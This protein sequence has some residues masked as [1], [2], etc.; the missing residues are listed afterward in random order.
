[1]KHSLTENVILEKEILMENKM[2]NS[3]FMLKIEGSFQNSLKCYLVTELIEGGDLFRLLNSKKRLKE[4]MVKFYLAELLVALE[5]LH[6]RNI[7]YRDLKPENI[8]LQQNGHIKLADFGLCKKMRHKS[9]KTYTMCGTCEYQAPE[10]ILNQGYNQT[11][12]YWALGILAYELLYG[13]PPFTDSRNNHTNI[14]YQIVKQNIEFDDIGLDDTTIDFIKHLTKKN[15]MFRLGYNGI[16]EIKEHPFF[17]DIDWGKIRDLD[18]QPPFSVGVGKH[19]E[20]DMV[21]FKDVDNQKEMF[22]YAKIVGYSFNQGTSLNQ[23]I[24][25]DNYY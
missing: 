18:Y 4:N 5:E 2:K 22:K 21:R 9:D 16:Q 8:L 11:V 25:F 3:L 15:V 7:I 12:D 10:V 17:E 19:R 13:I 1:M 6:D 14:M 23:I 24:D 20:K